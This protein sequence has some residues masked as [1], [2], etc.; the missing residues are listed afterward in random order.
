MPT[1]IHAPAPLRD[2]PRWCVWAYEQ[3]PGEAKPRKI[4]QYTHGGRRHGKQGSPEDLAK[5]TTFALA[6]DAAARRGLDG[7]GFALTSDCGITALDFDDAVVDGVVDPAV[8]D[9]VRGTYAEYSPSGKGVRAFFRGDL[10]N[11]KSFSKDGGFSVETFSTSGFVTVTGNMLPFVDLLGHEDTVAKV[12]PEVETFCKERFGSSAPSSAP[13]DNPLENFSP[14][15][16]LTLQD[17][18]DLLQQL[19][20]DMSRP[21]W[22]KVALALSHEHGLDE[23]AFELF[24]DWSAGGAK[25]PGEEQVRHQWESLIG[26]TGH[27]P[28]TMATVKK[29][30]K[31]ACGDSTAAP[32]ADR[33]MQ[34]FEVLRLK[35]LLSRPKAEWLIKGILPKSGLVVI[36]GRSGSGKSFAAIDI[37]A[38]V[39]LGRPWRERKVRQ[40]Q[41]VYIA[42]EGGSGMGKRFQAWSLANGVNLESID[43]ATVIDAPNFLKKNDIDEVLAKLREHGP[44][45]L[46]V[47][48]T[49]AQVTPGANENSSEDM[50][51]AIAHCQRIIRE[52]G[53][54]VMLV[55]HSGKDES[56]GARGWSGLR[57]A[58][59]AE[60][61]ITSRGHSKQLT[62][63]KMKDG[64]DG[65]TF[66]F[67][68]QTL[69]VGLDEDGQS[70]T[71]CV[72]EHVAGIGARPAVKRKLGSAQRAIMSS[73]ERL[74][75]GCCE[76]DL[77][78]VALEA[79]TAPDAGKKDNRFGNLRRSLQSLIETGAL[80]LRE[81]KI[82]QS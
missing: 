19:D 27:R 26:R 20:P 63:T 12:T 61:E 69:Q 77:L 46:V 40:E 80:S 18:Y 24:N 41:V 68:L 15:L 1:H 49:L 30:V 37:A 66:P 28:V 76:A 32:I 57:A 8:A 29:M 78:E 6:R 75:D 51:A 47:V 50:G 70:E 82:F 5:L 65:M 25:Y 23:D 73:I 13:S 54:A 36:F 53:A 17:S 48:D 71:S 3:L 42:A 35:E 31:D 4:P 45:G 16:G 33:G 39:Q 14:K 38:H 60:I 34:R 21:E 7:V 9:L 72:V 43:I 52:T 22:F 64:E 2:L 58:A 44:V 55:H 67:R 10:G 59:D 81:G 56:R 62:I 11:R 79:T 74:G